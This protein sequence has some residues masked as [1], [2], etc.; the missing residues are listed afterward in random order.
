MVLHGKQNLL[1]CRPNMAGEECPDRIKFQRSHIKEHMTMGE[2]HGT[3]WFYPAKSE[4]DVHL[5]PGLRKATSA[6]PPLGPIIV[7]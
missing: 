6:F 5:S 1:N 2:K 3:G 4:P 7:D